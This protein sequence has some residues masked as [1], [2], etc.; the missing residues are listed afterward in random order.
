MVAAAALPYDELSD[1]KA[2]I[3]AALV[4]ARSDQTPVLVVFGANWCGDCRAL[5]MAFK[6]GAA[7]P[8]IARK[9]KVVKVNVGRFDRNVDVAEAYLA[10]REGALRMNAQHRVLL[11]ND[12]GA[13]AGLMFDVGSG[14]YPAPPREDDPTSRA[15]WEADLARVR[16]ESAAS[17]KLRSQ[18]QASDTTHHEM[19]GWL[20]D[21][22]QS[23]GFDVWIASNDRTRERFGQQ[24]VALFRRHLAD[25]GDRL[26]LGDLGGV[27]QRLSD[28][29]QL[30]LRRLTLDR[31][32]KGGDRGIEIVRARERATQI[33]RRERIGRPLLYG[34]TSLF[35]EQFALRHLEE[36]PRAD[37]LAIALRPAPQPL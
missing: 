37:E 26:R 1:A 17:S 2:D 9:F 22:G 15:A 18:Q 31:A 14:R 10:L 19:Q 21:L 24:G 36:L 30:N 33:E 28:L 35:L 25:V 29:Q 3:S 16:E 5:D 12:L 27:S 7:A 6:E 11:S 23:L 20:R 13:I 4:Q 32:L 34:T 8:L